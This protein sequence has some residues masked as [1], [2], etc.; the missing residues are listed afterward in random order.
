MHFSVNQTIAAPVDAVA[1]AYASAELYDRLPGSDRLGPPDVLDREQ[2]GSIV[3]LRI[4]YRFTADLAPAVTAVVDPDK[5]TWVES[6]D[7]KGETHG[8]NGW[9]DVEPFWPD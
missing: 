4:R 6:T 7:D 9:G 5:L 3:T 8:M 1:R 2:D